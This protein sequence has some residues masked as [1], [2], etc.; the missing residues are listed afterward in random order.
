M[1]NTTN[2]Q[3]IQENTEF[4]QGTNAIIVHGKLILSSVLQKFW[5]HEDVEIQ[6][7]IYEALT[8]SHQNISSESDGHDISYA[9]PSD[10]AQ[11]HDVYWISVLEEK[12]EREAVSL[13]LNNLYDNLVAAIEED[14]NW[15]SMR[16]S[17]NEILQVLRELPK[18]NKMLNRS[19]NNLGIE[20]SAPSNRLFFFLAGKYMTGTSLPKLSLSELKEIIDL[21]KIELY[22]TEWRLAVQ[23]TRRVKTGIVEWELTGEVEWVKEW[24]KDWSDEDKLRAKKVSI[25]TP[26]RG[27]QRNPERFPTHKG[28]QTKRC[29]HFTKKRKLYRSRSRSN[30]WIISYY[31]PSRRKFS[32]SNRSMWTTRIWWRICFW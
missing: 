14:V 1:L 24:I 6:K 27:D 10:I 30:R 13:K 19:L 8:T 4:P 23:E 15:D 25:V 29:A 3:E 18:T 12:Q 17:Y 5:L 32:T 31:F 11:H 2:T 9:K 22:G 7:A 20:T 21:R 26:L 16:I 28:I